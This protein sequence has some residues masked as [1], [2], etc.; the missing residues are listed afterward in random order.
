MDDHDRIGALYEVMSG[1]LR[2]FGVL[3]APPRSPWPAYTSPGSCP[4]RKRAMRE[5]PSRSPWVDTP[6]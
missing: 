3:P 5:R 1:Y 4:P 2:G 6:L